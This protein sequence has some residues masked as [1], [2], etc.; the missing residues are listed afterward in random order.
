MEVKGSNGKLYSLVINDLF[1]SIVPENSTAKVRFGD[2]DGVCVGVCDHLIT[3]ANLGN[4]A[5]L[6]HPS[7][8]PLCS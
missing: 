6:L 3:T 8:L 1:D 7:P 2:S 5:S 4:T